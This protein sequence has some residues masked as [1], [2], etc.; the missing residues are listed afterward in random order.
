MNEEVDEGGRDNYSR[1]ELPQD[2]EHNVVHADERDGKDGEVDAEGTGRKHGENEP[3]PKRNVVVSL[4]AGAVACGSFAIATITVSIGMCKPT[5]RENSFT[6]Q[7]GLLYA[8]M[9]MAVEPSRRLIFMSIFVTMI[10]VVVTMVLVLDFYHLDITT[11]WCNAEPVRSVSK[12]VHITQLFIQLTYN[13]PSCSWQSVKAVGG[14]TAPEEVIITSY[15]L[16]PA[17]QC[18]GTGVSAR[19]H[20]HLSRAWGCE[21]T[22]GIAPRSNQLI[23]WVSRQRRPHQRET[24]LAGV[25]HEQIQVNRGHRDLSFAVLVRGEPSCMAIRFMK[26]MNGVKEWVPLKDKDK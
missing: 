3:D 10:M 25:V 2:G 18:L 15:S 4:Y 7:D 12:T 9:E 5:V 21:L 11:I 20:K 1:T 14:S 26:M 22:L 13:V 23:L 24:A 8:G 17:L 19:S 16:E 6:G